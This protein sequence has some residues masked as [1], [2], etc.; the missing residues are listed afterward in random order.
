M[1]Y[2]SF[3]FGNFFT[4]QIK[5][6][7]FAAVPFVIACYN[8]TIER[9]VAKSRSTMIDAFFKSVTALLSF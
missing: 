1:S 8:C 9:I 5:D 4:V 7:H 6:Q 2:V 3:I